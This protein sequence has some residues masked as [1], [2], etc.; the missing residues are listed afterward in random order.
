[1][2]DLN[3]DYNQQYRKMSTEEDPAQRVSDAQSFRERIV[4]ASQKRSASSFQS[5]ADALIEESRRRPAGEVI[6]FSDE[7]LR[8]LGKVLK[9]P[10][11]KVR[12]LCT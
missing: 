3:N 8:E 9:I 2:K 10:I 1:M 11:E 5:V 12:D 6:E 4:R 7:E